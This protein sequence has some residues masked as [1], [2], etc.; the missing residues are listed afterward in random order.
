MADS[1]QNP[2][3][4]PIPGA[5][6]GGLNLQQILKMLQTGNGM[7]SNS[8][9]KMNTGAPPPPTTAAS[10]GNVT[11]NQPTPPQFGGGGGVPMPNP[12][13]PNPGGGISPAGGGTPPA[14]MPLNNSRVEYDTKENA[15]SGSVQQIMNNLQQI[16]QS[17]TNKK[18]QQRANEAQNYVTQINQAQ[19]AG[20]TGMVN[21][22]LSDPK[23][24]KTIEKGLDY[25]FERQQKMNE[26]QEAPPPEA[27]GLQKAVEAQ[28]KSQSSQGGQSQGQPQSQQQQQNPLQKLMAL[29]KNRG[30]QQPQAQLP[31]PNTP[32]GVMIPKP[33]QGQ[34]NQNMVTNEQG[35][36][37]Q[38]DP[39]YLRQQA[40]GSTLDSN[41]NQQAEAIAKGL[42]VSPAQVK[43]LG[44]QQQ[45]ALIKAYTSMAKDQMTYDIAQ[46][47]N[48]TKLGVAGIAGQSRI[49]AAQIAKSAKK[50][51]TDAIKSH[52]NTSEAAGTLKLNTA[53][54][55][56]Y[57]TMAKNY[58][59]L[60]EKAKSAGNKDQA[61]QFQT[62]ADGFQKKYDDMQQGMADEE[63]MKQFMSPTSA[64]DTGDDNDE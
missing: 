64:G 56:H 46:E 44:M 62:Q 49:D 40:T 50:Y 24:V 8:V 29:I 16:I 18:S 34:Q 23:V 47:N 53:I 48:K 60:S 38:S 3:E 7:A 41:Q 19:A 57:T 54:L 35:R 6:G 25:H 31:M 9:N 22:L 42:N 61:A 58:S 52:W 10:V 20:D 63:L 27:I 11:P 2:Q 59:S 4:I 43:A 1:A 13:G 45:T 5:V 17:F 55:G 36:L 32:G 28:A 14:Q 39:T 15:K 21:A 30:Q 33:S 26:P 51:A 12:R 37:L